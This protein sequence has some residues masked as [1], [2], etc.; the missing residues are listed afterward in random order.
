MSNAVILIGL[1]L[2]SV[3]SLAAVRV[4]ASTNADRRAF[5][6]T[7][8]RDTRP[9]QV[10][11]FARSLSGLLPPWWRRWLGTPAVIFEVAADESGIRHRLIAPSPH[12]GYL[13]AQLRA[14]M[15]GT[16]VEPEEPAPL[17]VGAAAE[18][19][20]SSTRVPLRT[21]QPEA[22]AAGLLATLQPRRSGEFSV[23]QWVLAPAPSGG[24]HGSVPVPSVLAELTWG[25]S[26]VQASLPVEQARAEREKRSEP[27]VHAVC[28][29]GV[30]ADSP[31]RELQLLRRM[32]GAF[33]A[34]NA[35]GV[36]FRVRWL[37]TGIVARRIERRHQD[38]WTCLLNAKEV[39]S[40]LGVPM[41][42]PQLPGVTLS[43]A[44]DLPPPPEL[45]SR[46]FVIG[47]ATFR[48]AERVVAVSPEA[49]TKHASLLGATGSGKTTVLL[50]LAAQ[51]M[52]AGRSLVVIEGKDLI[53]ELRDRV[54]PKRVSDVVLLDPSDTE[55]PVGFNLLAG[56]GDAPEL[57]VDQVVEL[58][59]ARHGH[60]LGP[61]SEHVLRAGLL[62]LARDP[63]LTICEFARLLE[64]EA[65]RRRLLSRIEDPLGVEPFW[66]WFDS[67][68]EG[69]RMQAV[70]PLLN[71]VGP[72]TIRARLRNVVGQSEGIDLRRVI[73]EEKILFA[74]L[75]HGLLGQDAAG[76]IGGVLLAR[77][78]Q[79]IQGR[80]ALPPGARHPVY[81]IVDEFQDY[82][83][84]GTSFAAGLAQARSYGL[85]LVLSTQATHQLP[86]DV[87]QALLTNAR[88]KIC[89][90]TSAADAAVLAREFSPHLS[91]DDL[92]GLGQFEAYLAA[93]SGSQVLP[94]VSII[95]L[96]PAPPTGQA[97]AVR[98]HS[99]QT[100]GR[101]A[102][103]VEATMRARVEASAPVAAVGRRRRR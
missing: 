23:I 77:L 21:D 25:R 22:T 2:L 46:G 95:T 52:A 27:E 1:T 30:R 18:L 103:E 35:P 38:A 16:R 72:Y 54:P 93:V 44:R 43:G 65:F 100:Y 70:S 8:P 37:P 29:L 87:R 63:E 86:S 78:W 11:A 49:L 20:V 101:D 83:G 75:P 94:P 66:S 48:G 5:R 40:F 76:L 39:A 10:V 68:S 61:R 42:A 41:G 62:T 6:L 50:N 55:R 81:V 15:P 69:E 17:E 85:G 31:G 74:S 64:D 3:G 58:F 53:A 4:A 98:E 97:A 79:V 57:V 14:A 32:I 102:T 34:G 82:V 99:R 12:A 67:L 96:P 90:Q 80:A 60:Y 19:R 28:R 73:A 7:F 47:R 59:K 45:P 36:S 9:E 51:I 24:L 89:L 33:H 88:T 56:A 92:L 71:K 26:R 91:A 13:V 84:L